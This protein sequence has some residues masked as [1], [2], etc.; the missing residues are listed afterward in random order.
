[1]QQLITK[2]PSSAIS[3]PWYPIIY[4]QIYKDLHERSR[5]VMKAPCATDTNQLSE[6]KEFLN[7]VGKLISKEEPTWELNQILTLG[8]KLIFFDRHFKWETVK[9]R[10]LSVPQRHGYLLP[11][12]IVES[13]FR[14]YLPFFSM[15]IFFIFLKC[16]ESY[17][18][19]DKNFLPMK[20]TIIGSQDPPRWEGSQLFLSPT[21]CLKPGQ[22]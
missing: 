8:S 15:A 2:L 11:G 9:D 13:S 3:M 18:P 7:Y 1:M 4:L 22:C 19:S 20:K 6:W 16:L 17:S 14:S 5:P 10:I 12:A 21:S